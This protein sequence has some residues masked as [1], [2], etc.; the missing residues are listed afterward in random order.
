MTL[1][2]LHVSDDEVASNV[3]LHDSDA[4]EDRALLRLMELSDY[5]VPFALGAV[6]ELGIADHL[7]EDPRP[8]SEIAQAC[9]CD[10][11]ALERTL[12]ALASKG[13]FAE[14]REG[15]FALTPVSQFLQSSHP[16]SLRHAYTLWPA[17]VTAWLDFKHTL[18]TGESSFEHVHGMPLFDYLA[19]NP[20]ESQHF[21]RGMEALTRLE[22][23]SVL[24]AYP[25]HSYQHV[26]DVGGG[27]G[28]FLAGILG[29]CPS[30][31]GTL[32][33]LPHVVERAPDVFARAGVADRCCAQPGS[34]FDSAP[35]GADLYLMKRI[36]YSW[37][38]AEATVILRNVRQAMRAESR[39]LII[40]PVVLRGGHFDLARVLD[41]QILQQ[42]GGCARSRRELRTLLE[43]ADLRLTRVIPT[44]I[45]IVEAAPV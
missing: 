19:R 23:R 4:G 41:V 39:L 26:A 25:F 38:D 11:A 5:I 2:R 3:A 22:L 29:A 27:N 12:R 16:L 1:A 42:G 44:P 34:F 14:P 35:E 32:F 30:L 20:A 37:Q 28:T 18:R 40:E 36:V 17:D 43:A 13:V 6:T 21:D 10:P 15:W 8:V 33:D 9:D 45:P 31:R 7:G 24:P